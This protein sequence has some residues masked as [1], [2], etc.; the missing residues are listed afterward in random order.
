MV[1]QTPVNYI[2]IS[3]VECFMGKDKRYTQEFKIEVIKQI[4]ARS[5]STY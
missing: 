2:V 5:Y 3:N 4:K 1:Y